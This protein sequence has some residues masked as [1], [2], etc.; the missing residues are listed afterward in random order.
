MLNTGNKKLWKKQNL[1]LESR[2]SFLM[3]SVQFYVLVIIE[4]NA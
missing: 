1:L 4:I 2:K 3:Q